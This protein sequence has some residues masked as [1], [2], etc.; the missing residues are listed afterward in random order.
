MRDAP[1]DMGSGRDKKKK[2][3]EKRGEMGASGALKVS[4]RGSALVA[5]LTS[6]RGSQTEKKTERNEAKRERRAEAVEDWDGA[7]DEVLSLRCCRGAPVLT[8]VALCRRKWRR[9]TSRK[10]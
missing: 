5:V 2:A 8:S 4:C 6:A 7:S 1:P 10:S 9:R 3:K